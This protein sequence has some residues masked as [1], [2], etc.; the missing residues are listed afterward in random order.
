MCDSMTFFTFS[1]FNFKISPN[2]MILFEFLVSP[3]TGYFG[4]LPLALALIVTH[5]DIH[6]ISQESLLRF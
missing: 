1:C 6:E 5:A 3:Y 4:G 2:F